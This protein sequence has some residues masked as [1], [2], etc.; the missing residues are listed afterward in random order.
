MINGSIKVFPTQV[1]ISISGHHFK[2]TIVNGEKRHIEGAATQ[3]KHKDVLLSLSLIQAICNSSCCT[4]RMK[5]REESLVRGSYSPPTW[6]YGRAL[7][8]ILTAH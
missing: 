8:P 5:R 1:S 6:E 2:D 3:V 4:V 7:S